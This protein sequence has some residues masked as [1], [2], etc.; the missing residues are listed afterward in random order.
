MLPPEQLELPDP[1]SSKLDVAGFAE[2]AEL[3]FLPFHQNLRLSTNPRNKLNCDE[4]HLGIA[5]NAWSSP[6]LVM[7]CPAISPASLIEV[8]FKSVKKGESGGLN[9]SR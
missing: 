2:R 5:R 9:V 4:D 1:T 6:L 7:P 8:A 3:S